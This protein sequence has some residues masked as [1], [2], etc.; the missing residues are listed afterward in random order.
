MAF[1]SLTDVE[2]LILA[3]QYEIMAMQVG[4]GSLEASS[5]LELADW[6]KKGY[7]YLYA[8]RLGEQVW[9]VL[10]EA[11]SDFVVDVLGMYSRLHASAAALNCSNSAEQEQLMRGAKFPGFDGNNDAD[12]LTFADALMQAGRYEELADKS[13]RCPRSVC[14]KEGYVRMLRELA[15]FE[16]VEYL[17]NQQQIS[18]VLEARLSS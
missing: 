16:D 4:H 11:K 12:I 15:K 1:A 14:T 6:L 3:N 9:P 2:R 10:G 8:D 17:L 7:R 18:M 13:G 5:Y